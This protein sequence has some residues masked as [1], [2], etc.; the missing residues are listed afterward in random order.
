MCRAVLTAIC[1]EAEFPRPVADVGAVLHD[2]GK[3]GELSYERSSYTDEGQ[4]LV[5]F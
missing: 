3:L 4:L 2:M 1:S 5:T